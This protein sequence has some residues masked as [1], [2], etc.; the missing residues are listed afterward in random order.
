MVPKHLKRPPFK[1]IFVIFLESNKK[2]HFADGLLSS[3]EMKKEFYTSSEK[4]MIFLKKVFKF[5]YSVLNKSIPIK[6]Q[7]IIKGIESDKA[8]EF[9]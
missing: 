9:L 8:N 4:K 7:S 5:I 1:Y 2:T 6:P 3:E